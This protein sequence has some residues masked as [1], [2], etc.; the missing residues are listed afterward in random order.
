MT[1]PSRLLSTGLA[2]WLALVVALAVVA[3]HKLGVFAYLEIRSWGK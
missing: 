3:A 1:R 2:Y